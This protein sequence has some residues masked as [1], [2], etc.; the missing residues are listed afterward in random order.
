MADACET[1]LSIRER[2][3]SSPHNKK[4]FAMQQGR[5][6]M[7]E[8]L[9]RA[10]L[11]HR[12]TVGATLAPSRPMPS[13]AGP[14]ALLRMHVFVISIQGHSHGD[15]GPRQACLACI[16]TRFLPIRDRWSTVVIPQ[17]TASVA[18]HT[19]ADQNTDANVHPAERASCCRITDSSI[20]PI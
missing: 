1:P 20:N 3:P 7:V 13:N 2:R 5:L 18:S 14:V 11:V 6:E 15:C 16:S 19:S 8:I 12:Q 17:H 4:I 9:L 10:Q